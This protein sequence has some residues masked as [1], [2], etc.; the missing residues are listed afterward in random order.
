M[1]GAR[2]VR[3]FAAQRS[4]AGACFLPTGA[5][6][7]SEHVPDV[8]PEG[9]GH[10]EKRTEGRVHGAVL[11]ALPAFVVDV[12][13]IGRFFLGQA[14]ACTGGCDSAACLSQNAGFVGPIPSFPFL[15][16]RCPGH[17]SG[18]AYRLGSGANTVV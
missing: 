11:Q 15:G 8:G 5:S 3:E 2:A 1:I 9:L 13:S 14:Q 6:P 18:R 10:A 7:A 4:V 16:A 12:G 17:F